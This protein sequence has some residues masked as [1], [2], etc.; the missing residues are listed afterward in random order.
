[1]AALGAASDVDAGE[2]DVNDVAGAA[3]VGAAAA[4]LVFVGVKGTNAVVFAAPLLVP[5]VVG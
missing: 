5:S 3:A 2:K 1:M 4:L